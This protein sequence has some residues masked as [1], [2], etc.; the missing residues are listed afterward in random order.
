MNSYRAGVFKAA[1]SGM[2]IFVYDTFHVGSRFYK[3]KPMLPMEQRTAILDKEVK[4]YVKQGYRVLSQT[5]TSAQLVK[6]K[7]FNLL[8]ALICLILAV[9]PFVLYLLWYLAAKDS[10]VYLTVDE[11]GKVK[12]T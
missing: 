10:T 5:P 8:I 4:S 2:Q 3:E 6:P 9:L 7:K 1:E 11:Q 12:R